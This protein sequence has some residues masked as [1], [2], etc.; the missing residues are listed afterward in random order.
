M[1][2]WGAALVFSGCQC[3]RFACLHWTMYFCSCRHQQQSQ[4][5]LAYRAPISATKL[6]SSSASSIDALQVDNP[7]RSSSSSSSVRLASLAKMSKIHDD[8]N[9]AKK[10]SS[11][12]TSA[13]AS[14]DGPGQFPIS[15]IKSFTFYQQCFQAITPSHCYFFRWCSSQRRWASAQDDEQD[16]DQSWEGSGWSGQTHRWVPETKADPADC[17]AESA[18]RTPATSAP[19]ATIR[20][21]PLPEP[22]GD[23]LDSIRA[24]ASWVYQALGLLPRRQLLNFF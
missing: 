9:Y 20:L 10:P 15:T 5:S 17:P 7:I 23:L 19:T 16:G 13:T 1:I 18:L 3:V 14:A 6:S 21:R 24:E 12:G 4:Q 8:H 22:H 11:S 2:Q